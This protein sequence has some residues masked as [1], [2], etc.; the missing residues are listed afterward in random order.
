MSGL[1]KQTDKRAH[2]VFSNTHTYTHTDRETLSLAHTPTYYSFI[3]IF[4]IFW[5]CSISWGEQPNTGPET[6]SIPPSV[7]RFFLRLLVF[8][9]SLPMSFYLHSRLFSSNSLPD[10]GRGAALL[11]RAEHRGL[12]REDN[13]QKAM[14]HRGSGLRWC[15]RATTLQSTA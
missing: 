9:L 8:H 10:R 11:L 4:F 14:V 13:T 7:S 6:G 5:R 12:C 2:L 3:S 1:R 15:H